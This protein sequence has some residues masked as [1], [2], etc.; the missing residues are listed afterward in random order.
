MYKAHTRSYPTQAQGLAALCTKP[1]E[2]D[3]SLWGGPYFDRLPKDPWGNDYV[4]VFPGKNSSEGFD[5]YSL[6]EDGKSATGGNDPDDVNN[7]DPES[8]SYYPLIDPVQTMIRRVFLAVFLG[9]AVL[10]VGAII[11]SLTRTPPLKRPTWATIVGILGIFFGCLGL[12]GAVRIIVMPHLME[13]QA[14]VLKSLQ[15]SIENLEVSTG[16]QMPL[17]RSSTE[18]AMKAREDTAD[19]LE[20]IYD[21]PDWYGTWS[22]VAGLLAAIASG[23]YVFASIRLL[24]VKPSAIKLFYLAVGLSITVTLLRCL[25]ATASRSLMAPDV[26]VGSIPAM[27]IHTVLVTVVATGNKEAFACERPN[28]ALQ[29][30]EAAEL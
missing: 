28:Q 5:L 24:Q 7:W 4:Y 12:L 27:V 3:S 13:L 21:L 15:Q 2:I 1:E 19:E 10:V 26:L 29:P 25:V 22:L 8:G 6:G 9:V 20:N 16:Q 17:E 11:R 14:E 30:T 23:L 18:N